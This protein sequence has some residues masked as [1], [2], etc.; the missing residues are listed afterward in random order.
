M[1]DFGKSGPDRKFPDQ[2]FSEI[3]SFW[4]NWSKNVKKWPNF[5]HFL[6]K[7]SG[8]KTEVAKNRVKNTLINLLISFAPGYRH[9]YFL[10]FFALINLIIKNGPI[11]GQFLDPG[12]PKMA[13]NGRFLGVF[14]KSGFLT[15][16]GQVRSRTEKFQVA[17]PI[18]EKNFQFFSKWKFPKKVEKW[19]KNTFFSCFFVKNTKKTHF[20]TFLTKIITF[21]KNAD[22]TV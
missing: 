5:G 11:F 20:L 12:C 16:F 17:C 4:Q 2:K 19:P 18:F 10:H 8:P 14:G 13:K 3:F 6:V 1:L 9:F 21:C 7:K 15:G 22:R